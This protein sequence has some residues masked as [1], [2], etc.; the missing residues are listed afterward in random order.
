MLASPQLSVSA[1]RGCETGLLYLEA[2]DIDCDSGMSFWQE[3]GSS[4]PL[5][6]PVA[7]DLVS[8]PTIFVE[9]VFSACREMI[10][11]I[12]PSCASRLRM[13]PDAVNYVLLA[14]DF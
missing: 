14:E 1:W 4:C 5:L 6:T 13:L 8:A 3:R 9:R 7:E 11:S 10:H 2:A 12:S